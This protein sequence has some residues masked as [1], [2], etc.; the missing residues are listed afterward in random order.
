MF[1]LTFFSLTLSGV[2]TENETKFIEQLRQLMRIPFFPP[3]CKHYL[4]PPHSLPFTVANFFN[5]DN[6]NHTRKTF[7]VQGDKERERD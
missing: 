1:S 2:Y 7:V 6:N 5:C 3:H 4:S